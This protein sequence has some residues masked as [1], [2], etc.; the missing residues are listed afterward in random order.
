MA[1]DMAPS[2][3]QLRARVL[4]IDVARGVANGW[5]DQRPGLKLREMFR[6]N[7]EGLGKD[8]R[9]VVSVDVG[10]G[11][12][13]HKQGLHYH[14]PCPFPRLLWGWGRARFDPSARYA[15]GHESDW[16]YLG[17]FA[18]V[19][20]AVEAYCGHARTSNMEFGTCDSHPALRVRN[21]QLTN[22]CKYVS[23][24]D[25]HHSM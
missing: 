1:F 2:A 5:K 14:I 11:K 18:L 21:P 17:T 12:H 3:G 20:N 4:E 22:V 23:P 10:G 8:E 19:S 25:S 24:W 16:R 6:G 15:R 9:V 7:I 13:A